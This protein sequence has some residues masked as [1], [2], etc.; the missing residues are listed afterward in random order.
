V[1]AAVAERVRGRGSS[2]LQFWRSVFD[3][4]APGSLATVEATLGGPVGQGDVVRDVTDALLQAF[5]MAYEEAAQTGQLPADCLEVWSSA[6]ALL[7]SVWRT[8]IASGHS[9]WRAE[10][11]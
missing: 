1:A 8:W 3:R 9:R 5:S 4:H 6:S 7:R 2:Y 11:H 10:H